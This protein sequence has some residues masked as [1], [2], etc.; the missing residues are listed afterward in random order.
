MR[1]KKSCLS[2]VMILAMLVSFVP[3]K[4]LVRA[5]DAN[6]PVIP[7]A[8]LVGSTLHFEAAPG[9]YSYVINVANF[10]LYTSVSA[11]T[12]Y[13]F[14]RD[15]YE[16]LKYS[17]L[18]SGN[19]T[20]TV[21]GYERVNG[22]EV[23]KTQKF[24]APFSYTSPYPKLSTPTNFK[25][26]STTGTLSWDPVT[27]GGEPIDGVS[28]HV[29]V[30]L[31][32]VGGGLKGT[33]SM[34]TTEPQCRLKANYEEGLFEYEFSVIA[35]KTNY[36]QSDMGYAP[37]KYQFY[38]ERKKLTGLSVSALGTVKW[39]GT[40]DA[41]EYHV[42]IAVPGQDVV[43]TTVK[44]AT[45]FKLADQIETKG[46]TDCDIS[47]KVTAYYSYMQLSNPETVTY[48][49]KTYPLYVMDKQV[50]SFWNLTRLITD[51]DGGYISYYPDSKEIILQLFDYDAYEE[52][53]KEQ[54]GSV[55][56]LPGIF[57]DS[58]ETLY[59]SG[60]ADLKAKEGLF[61]CDQGLTFS[62]CSVAGTS[63]RYAIYAKTLNF[64]DC[65][66]DIKTTGG[67]DCCTGRED[68]TF[69]GKYNEI[70]LQANGGYSALTCPNG[71]INLNKVKIKIPANGTLGSDKHNIYLSD[72]K[73]CA[74]QVQLLLTTPTPTPKALGI[75]YTEKTIA[76]GETFQF[77]AKNAEGQAVTWRTGNTSVATVN[78]SGKV[79]AKSVGNTYLYATTP[80]NRVAKC[81]LKIV[82]AKPLS[83]T[84]TEKTINLGSTFTFSAKN[85]AGQKLTWSIGNTK[86]AT[87]D[88]N[89]K[90]TAKAPGNTYLTVKSSDGR[91][92]KCLIKVPYPELSLRYTEKTVYL[93][94]S[95][96][97]T[98]VNVYDQKLTWRVGNTSIATVDANGKVTGKKAGNTY[99]YAKSADGRETKCLIKVVDPGPLDIRYTEK[100]IKV[101]SS[102]T[103]T[104][105]NPAGQ[106]V[107]W[108][109][110]N[111]AI[112][113]VD[114]NGK[115][116]GKKAGNTYLYASTPD[117]REVKCLLKIVN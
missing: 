32:R 62:Q 12:N 89:G 117:G 48:H 10:T 109:V 92:T 44:D 56:E 38:W 20:V 51:G 34:G 52:K 35:S 97:F 24:V 64:E 87:V 73:T 82:E 81:L 108:R 47:V 41:T 114:A 112:A 4:S 39:D 43:R 53:I 2:V 111:T 65:Y 21:Y 76:V 90:V 5:D 15:M 14:D 103:F 25:F 67:T 80:D 6:L 60:Y 75:S 85:A 77:S 33:Y 17:S 61:H 36:P 100:T 22:K 55:P 8:S 74:S 83:I 96:K 94:T 45:S 13:V 107:T 69:E 18:P 23:Q 79:I 84:Y 27:A 31:Q 7:N 105:K 37:G 9:I 11:G 28:Y 102:F 93:N 101:G 99:L 46:L 78:A 66:M 68:V 88:S 16:L 98:A 95:F 30:K 29:N 42:E 116:T 26:D 91:S 57:F 71:I 115:V 110:G 59:V 40:P 113:T 70:N 49:L 72:G 58:S 106:N 86:I 50:T 63:G 1:I 19:Y 54:T 104:A 3:F